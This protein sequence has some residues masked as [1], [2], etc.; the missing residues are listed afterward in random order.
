[1]SH[2]MNPETWYPYTFK[3][4]IELVSHIRG[5]EHFAISGTENELLI[6]PTRT[7]FL[8]RFLLAASMGSQNSADRLR[9]E[10]GTITGFCLWIFPYD[11]PLVLITGHGTLDME[12]SRLEIDI[13][14]AE[15][16]EFTMRPDR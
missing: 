15:S 9:Q 12:A 10:D 6:L 16:E 5:H 13:L 14:P 2:I 7:G 11:E 3:E 8:S 1:M 4:T